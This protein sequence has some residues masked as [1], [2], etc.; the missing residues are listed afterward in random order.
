MGLWSA[1]VYQMLLIQQTIDKFNFDPS[2]NYKSHLIVCVSCD[3]CNANYDVK[4]NN[5]KIAHKVVSKD[6]C[7][8]C[9]CL[10]RE[11][12]ALSK[13]GVSHTGKLPQARQKM[14]KLNSDRLKSDEFKER[15]RQTNL[16]KYGVDIASKGQAAKNKT[17]DTLKKKHG[18]NS[19][20]DI[21]G[22]KEKIAE[23]CERKYGAKTYLISESGK[24]KIGEIN[25]AKYGT[26]YPSQ[27]E[28]VKERIR[29]TNRANCGYDYQLQDPER[30]AKF[31]LTSNQTK[32]AKG[33]ILHKD[34]KTLKQLALDTGF[35]K[36]R[37]SKLMKIHGVDEAL[38]MSPK[39]SSLEQFM[40]KI[41][42]ELGCEFETQF[43]VDNRRA[44][45][46]IPA[47]NLIIETNGLYFHSEYFLDKN[48]HVDKRALYIK[49]GYLPLFFTDEE[50][51]TKTPIVKSIINN[52]L[53]KSKRIF[54]RK[55]ELVKNPESAPNFVRDS[56][57][58]GKGK[59]DYFCLL[60][61]SSIAACLQVKRIKGDEYEVSRFCTALD[62]N[63]VGGF[64]RLVKYAIEQLNISKLH[65]FI[66]QRYGSGTY[67][68]EM[69]FLPIAK[70]YP[71]FRWTDGT[72]SFH[73]L[74]FPGKSGY[75]N[76]MVKIWDCGQQ[77]YIK[78]IK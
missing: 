60:N 37:F 68:A 49:N 12:V 63:V 75:E 54:A 57:L 53:G 33:T 5:R 62:I 65:T 8:K 17:K 6:A 7:V 50:V 64:S 39:V 55:C 23:T 46:F 36:T 3:Y 45:F 31:A 15:A 25:R 69:G 58:M 72:K 77:R 2:L 32:I 47:A 29:Q 73:R 21:P 30:A 34:G 76:G 48:Y 1:E 66:D 71:S 61:N 22:V 40:G 9:R 27:N 51:Y 13:Y 70:A 24:K 16:A 42:T 41:L 52:K 59:G 35:S 28:E 20:A 38:T 19:T 26:E 67:L 18:A 11:E 74:K 44:D 56:H 4:V 14:S 10:K 43:K 78:S